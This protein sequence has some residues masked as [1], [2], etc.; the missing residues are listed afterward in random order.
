[1][2][3][4]KMSAFIGAVSLFLWNTNAEAESVNIERIGLEALP[5]APDSNRIGESRRKR[6]DRIERGE[7]EPHLL[8]PFK[9]NDD[10]L[11]QS[12]TRFYDEMGQVYRY[13][14]AVLILTRTYPEGSEVYQKLYIELEELWALY[15]MNSMSWPALSV[16]PLI[17]AG[18]KEA[19]LSEALAALLQQFNTDRRT[20]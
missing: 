8:V 15:A 1:M 4:L 20:R 12:G 17:A 11:P 7:L 3:L 5:E 6:I 16:P 2:R 9:V 19:Q 18:K 10:G 13:E 14:E